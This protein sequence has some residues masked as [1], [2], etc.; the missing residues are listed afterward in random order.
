MET[1]I[2]FGLNQINNPSPDWASWIFRGYFIISKAFIGW[3]AAVTLFSTK[4]QFIIVTTISLLADPV[5]LGFSKLFGIEPIVADT[6]P[7]SIPNVPG[8]T[9]APNAPLKTP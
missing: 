7:T 1:K 9:S 2:G 3:A 8:V 5:M 4:E 6:P